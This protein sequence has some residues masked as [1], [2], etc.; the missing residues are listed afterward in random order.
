MVRDIAGAVMSSD[1]RDDIAAKV[2]FL[3]GQGLVALDG[4]P[5]PTLIETHLSWVFMT[6]ELVYKL[7]K[8]VRYDFV[9][10]SSLAARLANCR[11]EVRLNRALA[12]RVYLGLSNLYWQPGAGF[13]VDGDGTGELVDVLV[14]M[15]RLPHARCLQT[16]LREGPV[17]TG[18]I[19]H[20]AARLAAFYR[21]QPLLS[22]ADP[23]AIADRVAGETTELQ[24]LLDE[25]RLATQLARALHA[26]LSRQAPILS[27]RARREVHGDLRPEHIYL[28]QAPVFIDRLEFS[29]ALRVMDPAEELAYL[30]L[31]CTRLGAEWIGRVFLECYEEYC[32]DR[33]PV[34]VS[35]FYFARR[36]LLWALL[37]ARHIERGGEPAQW[38]AAARDYLRR[39]LQALQV[40]SADS[41]QAR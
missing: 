4:H 12:P 24:S 2:A 13:S 30:Q 7:K 3:S 10:L 22:P 11:E 16:R 35:Q 14:R 25:P 26:A 15:R 9:D 18:E 21:G 6:D 5:A 40:T 20:A 32:G 39:G 31:E 19:A 29:L 37:A 17:D 8:P 33:V 28:G 27:R 1:L 34:A 38:H 36:A 23:A 41:A